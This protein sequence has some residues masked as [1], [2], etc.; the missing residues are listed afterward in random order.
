MNK[1]N[2]FPTEDW[3]IPVPLTSEILQ[4]AEQFAQEQSIPRKAQQVYLNTIAV[5]AVNNYLRI[6]GIPTNLTA[7]DSWNSAVRLVEDVADLWITGKGSLECRPIQS[8]TL[9]CSIPPLIGLEKIGYLIVE[10]DREDKQAI[11]RGFTA[12]KQLSGVLSID[13]LNSLEDLPAYLDKLRPLVNLSQWLRNIFETG[14]ET[15]EILGKQVNQPAFAF[16]SKL[17]INHLQRCKLLELGHKGELI[18]LIVT[19]TSEL[20]SNINIVVELKPAS[21]QIY[22]PANLQLILLDEEQQPII[23]TKTKEANQHIQ[24]DLTAE[25]GEHFTIKVLKGEVTFTE[26]FIV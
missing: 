2:Q 10:I 21:S 19:I 11:L 12:N 4:I 3:S 9:T 18:A 24:L 14:W 7:G 1:N 15:T 6:L 8:G 16:R 26:N 13:K 23:D 17:K 5:C 25:P 20:K 22:L